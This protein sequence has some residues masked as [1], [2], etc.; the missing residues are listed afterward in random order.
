MFSHALVLEAAPRC[1]N[2]R[3]DRQAR[4]EMGAQR[5]YPHWR[6]YARSGLGQEQT[7]ARNRTG[8]DAA[9]TRSRTSRL[10]QM[11]AGTKGEMPGIRQTILNTVELS[12]S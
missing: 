11:T 9:V 1:A 10:H 5:V 3:S 4:I 2:K 6:R 8:T 7:Q 12:T